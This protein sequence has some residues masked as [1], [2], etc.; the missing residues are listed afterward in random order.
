MVSKGKGEWRVIRTC[1]CVRDVRD[2]K[3]GMSTSVPN[4]LHGPCIVR[5]CLHRLACL[6]SCLLAVRGSSESS[7]VC[8][9]KLGPLTPSFCGTRSA[10]SVSLTNSRRPSD[11]TF[12]L[13]IPHSNTHVGL[14]GLLHG[15]LRVLSGQAASIAGGEYLHEVHLRQHLSLADYYET[16]ETEGLLYEDAQPQYGA[17]DSAATTTGPDPEHLRREREALERICAQTSKC[18]ATNPHT[19]NRNAN[20]P[21]AN[22]SMSYIVM[23]LFQDQR[24]PMVMHSYSTNIFRIAVESPHQPTMMRLHGWEALQTRIRSFGKRSKA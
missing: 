11:F 13:H 1:S 18:D 4:S 3:T 15:D 22:S 16:S 8:A 7:N 21:P 23:L 9:P 14:P 20:V 19:L 17:V 12:W 2:G 5:T 10:P 6:H 24:P